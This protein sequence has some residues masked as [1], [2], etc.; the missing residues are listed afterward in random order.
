MGLVHTTHDIASSTVVNG[1]PL[2]GR[3]AAIFM[4]VWVIGALFVGFMLWRRRR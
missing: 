4:T 3:G 1:T 2:S